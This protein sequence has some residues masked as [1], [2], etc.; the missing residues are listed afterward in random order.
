MEGIW[1]HWLIWWWK[2]WN[3]LGVKASLKNITS[4]RRTWNMVTCLTSSDDKSRIVI[5]LSINKSR[6]IKQFFLMLWNDESTYIQWYLLLRM[7]MIIVYPHKKKEIGPPA[8]S[9]RMHIRRG[10]VW[11]EKLSLLQEPINF[12]V[13]LKDWVWAAPESLNRHPSTLLLCC[14]YDVLTRAFEDHWRS[15]NSQVTPPCR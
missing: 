14:Y 8:A 12:L 6:N 13:Q 7:I 11:C 4:L 1:C 3:H 15:H 2:I 5:Q 9:I 10:S